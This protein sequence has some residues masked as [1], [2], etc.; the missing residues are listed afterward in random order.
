MTIFFA[1][2]LAVHGLIHL[3]GVAKAFGWAELPQLTHPVSPGLGAV[4]LIAAMLFVAAAVA[5]LAW[6]RGWWAVGAFAIVISMIAILPSRADA[7]AGALVNVVALI[8]I[9]F[10]FLAQG[11]YSLRAAFEHDVDR[12][13]GRMTRAETVTEADMARLPAPVQ[14]YL[15]VAGVL[16]QPRVRNFH[17]RMHG[18]IR[19][20]RDARWMPLTAEQYNFLDDPSR[21]FYLNASMFAIPVQGYHRFVGPSATMKVKAAALVTVADALGAEMNQ[22]ETVTLFNDMCVMAPAT[23]ID[24]SVTW[25]PVDAT[26]AR[27]WFTN[28]GRTIGAELTFNQAGELTNFCSDDRYALMPDGK[29][30]KRLR[31]ST[32]LT[33]YRSF[34][35]VRLSSAG[36]GRWHEPEGEYAYIELTLDDIAYNVRAR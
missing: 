10:G 33:A 31:W 34:G 14:R 16:G 28:A 12:G 3:L 35:R 15:R 32:P 4:W 30:V 23:L 17:V 27:A 2:V 22:A 29:T 5:L 13:L 36:E 11:P 25:E 24:P 26:T 6:P 7:K 1:V 20:G 21:F 19:S 18:R 9:F 8:G